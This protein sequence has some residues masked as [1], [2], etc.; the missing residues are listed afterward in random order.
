MNYWS[1]RGKERKEQKS[2]LKK[3][4]AEN[5]PNPESNL[6][7][8]VHEAHKSTNKVNVENLSTTHYNKIV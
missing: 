3:V 8:Q 1:P 4:I 2:Y 6:D 7:I 5:L